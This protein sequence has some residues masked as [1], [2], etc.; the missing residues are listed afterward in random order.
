[1]KNIRDIRTLTICGYTWRVLYILGKGGG[2]T[3]FDRQELEIG[4]E[5]GCS[6][7]SIWDMIFH[8]IDEVLAEYFSIKYTSRDTVKVIFMYEH[9]IL[10]AMS[11][12]RTAITRNIFNELCNNKRR[13][14]PR[15]KDPKEVAAELI[16][17]QEKEKK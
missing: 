11:R 15:K 16:M 9:E 2:D 13:R 14:T 5:E 4:Y 17:A 7:D 10:D 6:D 8:E 1:M 3:F 12:E